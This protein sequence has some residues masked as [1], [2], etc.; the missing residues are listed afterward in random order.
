MA[1]AAGLLDC[2]MHVW[3]STKATAR[4]AKATCTQLIDGSPDLR[5][6]VILAFVMC[7][8]LVVGH[9][10]DLCLPWTSFVPDWSFWK[11]ACHETQPFVQ[12]V[13]LT[14]QIYC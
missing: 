10:Y 13:S 4:H 8:Q 5:Y 14:E 2:A 7:H 9:A 1:S 11:E 12:P 3:G 6:D